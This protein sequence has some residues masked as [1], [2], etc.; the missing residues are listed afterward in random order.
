M[1]KIM[2]APDPIQ[3]LIGQETRRKPFAQLKASITALGLFTIICGVLYPLL[4]TGIAQL[5]FPYQA[6]GSLLRDSTGVIRGSRLLAQDFPEDLWFQ[7]R[8]SIVNYTA[9]ASGASNLAITS[10]AQDKAISTRQTDWQNRFAG[11]PVPLDMLYASGSGLDPEISQASAFAQFEHVANSR[12]LSVNERA[13]LKALIM[14]LSYQVLPGEVPRIN[15]VDLNF[16]LLNG[17]QQ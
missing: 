8:P 11:I 14:K 3:N 5:V 2:N 9:G 15:V 6:N 13:N 4:I 7:A 17:V 10:L 12:N 16:A 1:K